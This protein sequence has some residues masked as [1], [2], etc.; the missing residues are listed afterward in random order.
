L[1]RKLRELLPVSGVFCAGR[2][3]FVQTSLR[4]RLLS[5]LRAYRKS[6]LRRVRKRT[7]AWV[8]KAT[9]VSLHP[10]LGYLVRFAYVLLPECRNFCGRMRW[11][12]FEKHTGVDLGAPTVQMLDGRLLPNNRTAVRIRGIEE[13]TGRY[14]W[15]SISEMRAFVEGFDL[16]EEFARGSLPYIADTKPL[17]DTSFE[18][19]SRGI[20]LR[21]RR[22]VRPEHGHDS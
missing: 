11:L 14:P 9:P 5:S 4:S 18:S 3:V 7:W 13:L 15:A 6:R 17:E 8:W 20:K 2:L 10:S 19:L 22:S 1:H 16:G 12:V 21:E